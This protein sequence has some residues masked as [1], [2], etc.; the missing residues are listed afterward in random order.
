M[1]RRKYNIFYIRLTVIIV[2]AYMLFFQP[3]QI[4][5]QYWAYGYV[6][7]YLLTNIVLFRLPQ[8]YYLKSG[9]Y[10]CL[11]LFDT[12]MIT[13]GIFLSNQSD[14]VL[15]LIYFFIIGIAA[16]SMNLLYMML[17]ISVFIL[18]YGWILYTQGKFSGELAS[19]YALRLPFIF[20]VTLMFGYIINRI[21][22]DIQKDIQERE[23]KYFALV[24]S[25]NSPVYMVDASGAYLS[26][27]DTLADELQTSKDDI[28][29]RLF[30]DFHSAKESATFMDHVRQIFQDGASRMFESYNP[31]LDK[32]T[33]RTMSPLIDR[34]T[35]KIQAVSVV[36]KDTTDRVKAEH[37]LRKAYE[38]LQQTQEQLIRKNKMEALGRLSAGIAHQLRNPLE[39]IVMGLDFLKKQLNDPNDMVQMGLQKIQKAVHRADTIIEDFLQFSKTTEFQ[40][41]SLDICP[42]LEETIDM[43]EYKAKERTMKLVLEC[44]EP[45]LQVQADKSTL[46][47]VFINL[48]NNGLEAMS[49]GDTLTMRVFRSGPEVRSVVQPEAS[50]SGQGDWVV[51]QVIDS[52]EGIPE[53]TVDQI[54]EPF[55]TSK[56]AAKG[57]GLGLSIASMIIERHGGRIEVK[58][59]AGYGSTFSVFLQQ[60]DA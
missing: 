55:Y 34:E 21:F 15:Y 33:L 24:E 7:G 53:E 27:N 28:S 18:V 5:H 1:D 39:I 30:S 26:V 57:T 16:M 10:Y 46:Q 44:P 22:K 20:A 50:P 41:R 49:P 2:I 43:V 6:A 13:L 12:G 51:V 37:K 52:G 11:V 40:L 3:E 54:F 36:S 29:G 58:S 25:I 59:K 35:Q 9:F 14:M 47:Q 31:E 48:M 23:D 38:Q 45:W 42:F 8:A 17:N 32:W 4:R 56:G 19:L 60:A